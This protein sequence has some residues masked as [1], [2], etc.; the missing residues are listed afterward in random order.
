MKHAL[1]GRLIVFEGIDGT[2]KSTQILL[3]GEYL[4]RQ[5][6]EVLITREPTDGQFGRKIRKL[7]ADRKQVS[8]QEELELFLADRREH[9][10]TELLPA[11]RLGKIVLCDRYFLSTVAYQ[12]ANGF[13]PAMILEHNAFAPDPDLALI[14][15]VSVATSLK[16]ITQGRGEQLNDF[17]QEESLTRVSAIFDLLDLPYIT[18]IDAEQTIEEIHRAVITAAQNIVPQPVSETLIES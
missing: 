18:R 11:L 2:G 17:E 1:P 5:G 6:H 16:R 7:Y 3:L 13:D 10:Q 4:R 12:G 15:E 8:Q 9:C 14:F